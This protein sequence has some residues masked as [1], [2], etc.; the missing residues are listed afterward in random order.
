M[1]PGKRILAVDYGEKNIGFACSDEL[2]LTAQPLPSIPNLGQSNLTKRLRMMIRTLGIQELVLGM[3][4]NMDG[5]LGD[6]AIRM[7]QLLE[8]LQNALK[9][10][11]TAVDERLST[12]E[13]MDFWKQLSPRRQKK[14]RTVDS[15]SAAL[16]LE[17][18]LK[19]K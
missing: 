15:L 14:Y 13:A 19:E 1:D 2:G 4:I 17:R 7:G 6:S 5:T 18:Y 8:T 10:P 11:A 3:P 12:L 9:I 16:I